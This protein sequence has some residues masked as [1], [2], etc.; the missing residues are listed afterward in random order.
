MSGVDD[1]DTVSSRSDEGISYITTP[2]QDGFDHRVT[3]DI[4]LCGLASTED[5]NTAS[6]MSNPEQEDAPHGSVIVSGDFINGQQDILELNFVSFPHLESSEHDVDKSDNPYIRISV[7]EEKN[8]TLEKQKEALEKQI[9]KL[10]KELEIAL[11]GSG[12]VQS[13]EEQFRS[14]SMQQEGFREEEVDNSVHPSSFHECKEVSVH[15]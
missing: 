13:K 4:P 6:V 3:M 1:S 2:V 7:L 10:K 11:S 14:T 12:V 5:T 15:N 9:E 8:E